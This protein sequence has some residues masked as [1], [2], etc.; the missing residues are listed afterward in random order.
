MAPGPIMTRM[1]LRSA[2]RRMHGVLRRMRMFVEEGLH[3]LHAFTA[4]RA[5]PT[6]GIHLLGALA[7][8]R[9]N[10]LFELPVSQRIADAD[11]H[12]RIL[13]DDQKLD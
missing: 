5:A 3:H 9:G 12:G 10:R 13:V 4:F 8:S 11:I 7:L 6:G 1:P 2:L